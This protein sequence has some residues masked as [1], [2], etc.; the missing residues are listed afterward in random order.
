MAV[1]HITIIT[2]IPL[3]ETQKSALKVG[4]QKKFGEISLNEKLDE[5]IVGGI[6]VTVG[7]K[8]FDASITNKLEQLKHSIT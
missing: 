1:T 7:S 2:A 6:K 3:S 5:A 8:Q 4:L